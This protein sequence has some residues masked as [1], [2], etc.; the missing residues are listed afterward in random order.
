MYEIIN[1]NILVMIIQ[2]QLNYKID[3][4]NFKIDL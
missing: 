2:L 1:N 4:G 3:K